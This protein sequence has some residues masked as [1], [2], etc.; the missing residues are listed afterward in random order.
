MRRSHSVEGRGN[1]EKENRSRV[2]QEQQ[3]RAKIDQNENLG[4]RKKEIGKQTGP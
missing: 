1:K 2:L 3:K 4:M